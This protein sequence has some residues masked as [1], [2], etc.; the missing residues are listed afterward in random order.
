MI[1]TGTS[2]AVLVLLAQAAPIPASPQAKAKAQVLLKE[3]AS[4]YEKGNPAG[5]L[6]RFNEA[7]AE[8]PSPKLWFNIGQANRDLGR[9]A[10]AM[11]AL[12][13]FLAEARD[14]SAI[15]IGEAEKSMDELRTQLGRLTIECSTAGADIGVDGKPMGVSPIPKPFWVIPGSHQVTAKHAGATL[16]IEDVD[17]TAGSLQTVVMRLRQLAE[18]HNVT[19][20][21]RAPT[22]ELQATSSP[23]PKPAAEDQGWWLG[24]RWTWVAGGAAAVFTAAAVI[25][26][27]AMQSRFNSL[28][29]SCGSASKSTVACSDS[30][31]GSVS[32]LKNTANA[33]WG[34]AGAA[35]VTAGVLL[36]IE[37]R[38]V[39]VAPLAGE[40]TGFL[41]IVRY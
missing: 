23:A 35:A 34:L 26:G 33:F 22:A 5:A 1:M 30:D 8:Y 18:T 36:F 21:A 11:D 24:R 17:V 31:I 14:A 4:L 20:A 12:E 19:T 38:P 6:E 40:V 10:D 16:A 9:P 25:S 37:D 2:I 15:S 32:A 27:A 28:N 7:Y 3:G 13:R 29:G 41:A 39:G